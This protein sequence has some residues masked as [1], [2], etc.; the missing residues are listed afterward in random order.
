[1][2]G[3]RHCC[4]LGAG[5]DDCA[6]GERGSTLNSDDAGA[7]IRTC[8]PFADE[9]PGALVCNNLFPDIGRVLFVGC[10]TPGTRA[11]GESCS[12]EHCAAGSA[13]LSEVCRPLCDAD[14][15]CASGTCRPVGDPTGPTACL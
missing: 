14:D 7:C 15:S 2:G 12:S 1:M 11:A 9:C 13:Y 3:S 10:G 6:T 4:A 8:D 5:N